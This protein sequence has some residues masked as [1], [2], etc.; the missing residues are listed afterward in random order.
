MSDPAR[1]RYFLLTAMRIAAAAMIVAGMILA[2]GERDW[3][4]PETQRIIGYLLMLVGFLD[5]L[6][7]L[8]I[9]LRRWKT[10]AE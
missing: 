6:V 1:S 5:L 2:F 10:P 4:E 7:A 8:P 3:F 9:L